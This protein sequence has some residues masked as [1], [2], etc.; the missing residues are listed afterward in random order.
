[1]A[2]PGIHVLLK[3]SKTLQTSKSFKTVPLAAIQNSYLCPVATY[4]SMLVRYPVHRNSPLFSCINKSGSL[5]VITQ[6]SLRTHLHQI[7]VK[8]GLNPNTHTFHTFRR[9]GAS[10]A[11]Q[12]KVPI[13]DIQSHGTWSSDAVWTYI[14]PSLVDTAVPKAFKKSLQV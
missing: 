3:W 11:F 13:Q 10:F 8:L 6:Y 4:I 2:Q 12:N 5:Y 14:Q 7:M 1:M 9:S